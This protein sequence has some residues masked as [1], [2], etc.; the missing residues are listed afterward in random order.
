MRKDAWIKNLFSLDKLPIKTTSS[1]ITPLFVL[2][3]KV[4]FF[5]LN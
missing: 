4:K 1:R 2:T 5:G 3:S